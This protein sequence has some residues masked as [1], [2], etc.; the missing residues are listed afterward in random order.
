MWVTVDVSNTLSI[1][2]GGGVN[3]RW[4]FGGGGRAERGGGVNGAGG[5]GDG[6]ILKNGGGG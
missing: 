1:G 5:V 4:R 6:C 2:D 3:S